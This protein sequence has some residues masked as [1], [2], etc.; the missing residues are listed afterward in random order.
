MTFKELRLTMSKL[1]DRFG[2][3]IVG[4]LAALVIAS[5]FYLYTVI[6]WN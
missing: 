3:E 6:Y 5:P 2:A 4:V 1:L